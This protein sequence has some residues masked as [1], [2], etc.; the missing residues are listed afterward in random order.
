MATIN[1][2]QLM[3]KLKPKID[4]AMRSSAK[5]VANRIKEVLKH[6]VRTNW[7]SARPS[8]T[9]YERTM[10]V[11]ESITVSDVKKSGN[12]YDVKVYFDSDYIRAHSEEPASGLWGRYRSLKNVDVAEMIA[13]WM[14][15]GQTSSVYSYE[16]AHFIEDTIKDIPTNVA[17]VNM[18]KQE[19]KKQ[20]FGNV[21][22]SFTK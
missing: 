16:G 20:G 10:H 18:I 2:A 8:G 5:Q 4:S 1:K 11:L 12:K 17:Y 19:F 9:T 3:R 14:N 13:E 15:D 22:V 21:I 7:Y 6:F